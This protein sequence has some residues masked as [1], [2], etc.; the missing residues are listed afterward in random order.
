MQIQID[1]T[2]LSVLT[3]LVLPAAVAAVTDRFAASWVKTTALAVLSLLAAAA[4]T[5]YSDGGSFDLAG[6]LGTALAQVILAIA[7]HFQVLKP[8][9]LTGSAGFIARMLPGGLGG[10]NIA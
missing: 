6:F 7:V 8:L 5:A 2:V 4:Q 9:G 10:G 1:L 3:S